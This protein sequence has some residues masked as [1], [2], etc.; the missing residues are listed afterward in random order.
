MEQN[1]GF[2]FLE[3]GALNFYGPHELHVTANPESTDRQQFLEACGKLGIKAHVIYNEIPYGEASVDYLT[4]SQYECT[5]TQSFEELQ[6]VANGLRLAGIEVVREKI[7][8]TPWH[9]MAPKL[10]GSKQLEGS[11]F[12]SH[13]TVSDK[14]RDL[15]N[16][17][18]S[19]R[20]TP[21][22]ISTTEHKRSQ[23]LLFATLRHYKST[24][25]EFCQTVTALHAQL[26]EQLTVSF[27]TVEYALYDSNPAHDKT[28][29]DA[30]S[31]VLA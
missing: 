27:P 21:L 2:L 1:H 30:Y 17:G 9:P 14:L 4:G 8:T 12:E 25:E 16:K 7:E 28:W 22:L 24:S 11:Y 3:Q 23:R 29:V 6:R 31:T 19:F 26:Q 15:G 20:G 18:V 13:F 10:S 5:S